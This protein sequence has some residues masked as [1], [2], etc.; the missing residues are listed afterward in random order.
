MESIILVHVTDDIIKGLG[1]I[2]DIL[3]AYWFALI[4]IIER[5][6]YNL[7][8]DLTA[9]DGSTAG[10]EEVDVVFLLQGLDLAG[11]QTSVGE[12]SVLLLLAYLYTR[13]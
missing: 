7:S 6:I 9:T 2:F 12:H 5:D 4:S 11:C 1:D 10:L 8:G 3:R 13:E